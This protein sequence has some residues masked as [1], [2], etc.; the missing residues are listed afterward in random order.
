MEG[1]GEGEREMCEGGEGEGCEGVGEE[2]ID[3]PNNDNLLKKLEEQNRYMCTACRWSCDLSCDMLWKSC[4]MH[5]HCIFNYHLLFM[6]YCN[7]LRLLCLPAKVAQHTHSDKY[8]YTCMHTP[9]LTHMHV[10][11]SNAPISHSMVVYTVWYK[12]TVGYTHTV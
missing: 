1:V 5:L 10:R 6:F 4:D 2:D 7:Y 12:H 3:G 8:T 11:S 9:V